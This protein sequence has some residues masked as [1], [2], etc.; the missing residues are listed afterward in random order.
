MGHLLSSLIEDWLR[1][2]LWFGIIF[3]EVNGFVKS[4]SAA[5]PPCDASLPR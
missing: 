5:L 2:W 1:I 4:P 3:A